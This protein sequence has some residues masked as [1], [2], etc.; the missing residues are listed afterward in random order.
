MPKNIPPSHQT[1][2]ATGAV[3]AALVGLFGA[4]IILSVFRIEE[5][6]FSALLGP[7]GQTALLPGLS[8]T[9][10]QGLAAGLSGAK[11]TLPFIIVQ[12][13]ALYGGFALRTR[14]LRLLVVGL[15]LVMTLVIFGGATIS[16]NTQAVINAKTA[17]IN[18]NHDARVTAMNARYDAEAKRI[19]D[20]TAQDI[21]QI[22]Q[23]AQPRLDQ[24]QKELD[25]ERMVG[26]QAFKGAR[27]IEL[28]HLI[29]QK[30]KERDDRIAAEQTA[31]QTQLDKVAKDR[32]GAQA[33]L[34]TA[35]DAALKSI[36]RASIASSA[37]AQNPLILTTLAIAKK[38]LPSSLADPVLVTVNLSVMIS[39]VFELL[40][41]T[42]LGHAYRTFTLTEETEKESGPDTGSAETPVSHGRTSTPKEE[43]PNPANTPDQ[44][45]DRE[46]PLHRFARPQPANAIDPPANPGEMA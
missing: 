16:P 8:W 29:A 41:M 11:L 31:E 13:T 45:E 3:F 24:L 9:L 27:Y 32:A 43:T 36:N 6:A 1:M 22:S 46:D 44:P 5:H 17:S 21:K 34:D 37:A 33:A 23:E 40:P 25:A 19:T 38:L 20:Q 7:V 39:I 30:S 15:A 4:L 35:R 26:G 12:D 42:L 10:A 2:T 14:A 18:A 28:T